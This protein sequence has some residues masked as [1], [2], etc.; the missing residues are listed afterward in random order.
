MNKPGIDNELLKNSE[1]KTHLCL[2][3]AT[4]P[5]CNVLKI[6]QVV[7]YDCVCNDYKILT[8]HTVGD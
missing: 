3:C 1:P 4:R 2:W 5:V 6:Y 7:V 8:C